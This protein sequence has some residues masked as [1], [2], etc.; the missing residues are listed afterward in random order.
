MRRFHCAGWTMPSMLRSYR[1][2]SGPSPAAFEE[3]RDS[4][5]PPLPWTH[6]LAR[7]CAGSDPWSRRS[8]EESPKLTQV[9]LD[10]IE[11]NADAVA[12]CQML[13]NA[14]AFVE[15]PDRVH[16][17]LRA[18]CVSWTQAFQDVL[19][20]VY[21]CQLL[22]QPSLPKAPQVQ[23]CATARIRQVMV[24]LTIFT[25]ARERLNASDGLKQTLVDGAVLVEF[26]RHYV[27][28]RPLSTRNSLQLS[29]IRAS[30][31]LLQPGPRCARCSFRLPIRS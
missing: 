14:R 29:Q 1:V 31:R 28:G 21:V 26:A 4:E 12:V 3:A 20:A 2:K 9:E 15:E 11:Y 10:A 16:V 5:N 8:N 13:S 17:D 7:E 22:T 27:T 30:S 6:Q 25:Y 19:V 23:S 24:L 18:F